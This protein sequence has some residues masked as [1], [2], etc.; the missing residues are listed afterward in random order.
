[1]FPE[2]GIRGGRGRHEGAAGVARPYTPG[3]MNTRDVHLD[4][5]HQR[6]ASHGAGRGNVG[7][8]PPARVTAA[9][10]SRA[11]LAQAHPDRFPLADDAARALAGF[12]PYELAR[13]ALESAG[14]RTGAPHPSSSPASPSAS[15]APSGCAATA[16]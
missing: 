3:A 15:P 6:G 9:A 2:D 5:A 13:R 1:M 10:M 8:A 7:G 16:T 12:R 11:L 4:G 14:V